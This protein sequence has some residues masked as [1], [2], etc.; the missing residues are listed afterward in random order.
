[1]TDLILIGSWTQQH[2]CGSTGHA[3]VVGKTIGCPQCRTENSKLAN[4][5]LLPVTGKTSENCKRRHAL[6]LKNPGH[7]TKVLGL[8]RNLQEA[9]ENGTLKRKFSFD[10]H[11]KLYFKK[12][13]M[14]IACA[15]IERKKLREDTWQYDYFV[16]AGAQCISTSEYA[17][18]CLA[19]PEDN[20]PS[21]IDDTG[22]TMISFEDIQKLPEA[23]DIVS[24]AFLEESEK[25]L[26]S[27]PFPRSNPEDWS[28]S[29]CLS[30]IHGIRNAELNWRPPHAELAYGSMSVPNPDHTPNCVESARALPIPSSIK[31][32]NTEATGSE[33]AESSLGSGMAIT[34][35]RSSG[36]R[37]VPSLVQPQE[38][39]LQN[40]STMPELQQ[41][42]R[43]NTD[44]VVPTAPT[45]QQ[46][47]VTMSPFTEECV[48]NS[49]HDEFNDDEMLTS[50][51]S[52]GFYTPNLSSTLY[53]S[54][55]TPQKWR[56]D[57]GSKNTDSLSM[58]QPHARR[59][60]MLF[61]DEALMENDFLKAKR[62]RKISWGE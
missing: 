24:P 22:A 38:S 26:N 40:Y 16:R 7:P 15:V 25:V 42:S 19:R 49:I 54:Q 30:P 1:M 35:R 2:N 18:K 33:L 8:L 13:G 51:F 31:F 21:G 41:T 37:P 57:L 23:S 61:D 34:D 59:N 14:E 29:S 4:H 47:P 60:L 32:C 58:S 62:R 55:S 6:Q 10:G 50:G 36:T 56:A 20:S 53:Q 12:H 43:A 11:G 39:L 9:K 28:L 44:H 48:P 52:L 45:P 17:G 5:P 3:V 27:K 46:R